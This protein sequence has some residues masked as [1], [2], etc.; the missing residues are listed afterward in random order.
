MKKKNLASTNLLFNFIFHA[1]VERMLVY[2]K[3]LF[4][5]FKAGIYSKNEIRVLIHIG[6]LYRSAPVLVDIWDFT[7]I[8]CNQYR[9]SWK[10]IV[11]PPPMWRPSNQLNTVK[12]F[13]GRESIE[14]RIEFSK[15]RVEAL[16]PVM[17]REF[18]L[19]CAHSIPTE[20]YPW[21]I[22][23]RNLSCTTSLVNLHVS[24]RLMSLQVHLT[25]STNWTWT[26]LVDHSN[27][28]QW[29]FWSKTNGTWYYESSGTFYA[30]S[31]CAPLIS[32]LENEEW[33]QPSAS[34]EHRCTIGKEKRPILQK[35]KNQAKVNKV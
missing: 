33:S 16:T 26:T 32:R 3:F 12:C 11:L 21:E 5:V 17:L 6:I 35:K 10:L 8:V 24:G 34:H 22:V 31:T 30:I 18:D 1:V 7:L 9:S 13:F 29:I 14:H 2:I 27:Q 28:K 15:S 20:C 23:L 19:P 25:D 4:Q